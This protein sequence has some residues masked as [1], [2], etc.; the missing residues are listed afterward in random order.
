MS[1]EYDHSFA[2]FVLPGGVPALPDARWFGLM[3]ASH[4]R[5]AV[6]ERWI[7]LRERAPRAL[8]RSPAMHTAEAALARLL[9]DAEGRLAS[10]GDADFAYQRFAGTNPL[11]IARARTL[12]DVPLHLRLAPDLFRRVVGE[13][14]GLA[15]RIASGN[16][17]V[18]R[19]DALAVRAAGDLQPGKFMAPARALFCHAPE[20]AAPY[21]VIPVAIECAVGSPEGDTGVLTP[22]D[23]ARWRAAKRIVNV[24]D[25]NASEICVHLVRAHFM[26]V[27]FAIALGRTLP[28]R[29]PLHELL[30]PQLKFNLFVDRMAWLQGVRTD[31]GI[32][33]R[34]LAGSARW[35]QNVARSVYYGQSFREQHFERDL[36]ARGLDAHPVDYP[37]R[38]DGRL[39]WSAIRRFVEG[40][41]SLHYP[42]DGAVLG[43]VALQAFV[44]DLTA[45]EGGNVRGLLSGP[46]LDTRGEL[47]EILTQVVFVAGPLHAL[48]H[49]GS[50][51]QL[52]DPG[53]NPAFLTHNPLLD[54]DGAEPG[55]LGAMNQYTRVT[56]TNCRYDTLGDFS[57][58]PLGR[59]DGCRAVIERFQQDLRDAEATIEE[60]NRSRYAPF[61]HFLPSRISNGITV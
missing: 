32:L 6:G 5:A 39:L 31:G 52:Q 50:A 60:R 17:F 46:R 58:E 45:R 21:P 16:V 19:Y 20:L 4:L 53:D 3:A 61:V 26:T 2:P 36:A 11:Q 9:P 29:H 13:G 27:P 15:E 59:R 47:I 49:Y 12:D 30:H 43:D 14:P 1:I 22:L 55:P 10:N 56:G 38:D 28:P 44:D 33:V 8:K 24:A 23:G 34:S 41:V 51:A 57:A 37:Y 54:P 7:G 18:L 40:Y 25:V 42:D 35:T 48:A